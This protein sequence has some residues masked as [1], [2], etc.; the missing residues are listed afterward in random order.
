MNLTLQPE[1]AY[2]LPKMVQGGA[3]TQCCHSE[4]IAFLI[5]M[6]PP[7]YQRTGFGGVLRPRLSD[8]PRPH[9]KSLA[10]VGE[11]RSQLE[12]ALRPGAPSKLAPRACPRNSAFPCG[13][14]RSFNSL[15]Q[16]SRLLH[17][18]GP[19]SG[20]PEP[21]ISALH[22]LAALPSPR[23]GKPTECSLHPPGRRKQ[24]ARSLT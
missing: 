3:E 21:G 5:T 1:R 23:S 20:T 13:T 15:P 2:N 17:R 24:E 9:G 14:K 10:E 4:P 6:Y 11:N 8:L 22:L 12:A 19:A 16:T 18:Q 7:P